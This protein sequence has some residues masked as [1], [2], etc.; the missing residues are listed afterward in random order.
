VNPGSGLLAPLLLLSAAG[1]AGVSPETV[2]QDL[3]AGR[4]PGRYVTGVPFISQLDNYC[5]PASLAMVLRYWGEPVGQEEIG[6]E[7]YLKSVKGT[8]NLELEFYARRRGYRAESFRGTLE[9]LK[10]EIDRG[11]PLIVFQDQGIGPLAFPHFLVVIGYD[12]ARELIVAHS[13][14]T[15]HRL[16]PY[17]EFLWTWA[18]K[19]NWTLRIVP[20]D[21]SGTAASESSRAG[22]VTGVGP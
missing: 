6:R 2:R 16:I 12:D 20:P 17:R 7:L 21:G 10:A 13:G 9:A 11:H 19:G 3:L 22:E 18:K 1:C 5:G 15:E 4:S 14:V 8:L